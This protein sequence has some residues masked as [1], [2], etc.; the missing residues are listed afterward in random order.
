MTL[1]QARRIA[2]ALPGTLEAPHHHFTSWRLEA[3]GRI[4]AT[5]P[6]A[7]DALHVFVGAD[8]R[9]AALAMHPGCVEKLLWGGKVVGLRVWLAS[10]TPAIVKSLLRQAWRA[11]GGAGDPA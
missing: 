3:K 6:P 11:K 9:D 2:M 4:Y 8:E 7:G 5:A 10:A 1:D